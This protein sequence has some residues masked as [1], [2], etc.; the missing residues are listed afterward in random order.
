[1]P[2]M[3]AIG[4]ERF[5]LPLAALG[6]E[7]AAADPAT[8]IGVLRA[9]LADRSVA[10]VVCAE[11]VVARLG[12]AAPHA[13][14]EFMKLRTAA[15]TAVIIVPDGPGARGIGRELLR[16]DVERAAG[17]DLLKSAEPTAD[18]AEPPDAPEPRQT[19]TDGV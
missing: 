13:L 1:M 14:D 18:P 6:F 5:T 7:P 15:R 9:A 3:L 17:V 16:C 8:F 2:R 19:R 12:D 11:S 4:P 10:L